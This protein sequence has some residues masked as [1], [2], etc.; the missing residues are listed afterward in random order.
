M[1]ACALRMASYSLLAIAA[2]LL[3][4]GLIYRLLWH[5]PTVYRYSLAHYVAARVRRFS[6]YPAYL[7]FLLRL[8][9]LGLLVFVVGRPQLP[10]RRT[11][12]NVEG[13]DIIL[14]MDV[15]GSMTCFDDMVDRRSRICVAKQEAI[16]FIEQREH[17]AVGVVV[18][19]NG[20]LSACPLT[21]DKAALREIVQSLDVGT[22]VDERCT[23]LSCG[24]LAALNRLKDTQ[25]TSKIIILLTDGQPSLQDVCVQ[26]PIS[27][28][29]R[30]GVKIYTIGIGN[31]QGGFSDVGGALMRAGVELN[32]PLLK[33]IAQQTGGAYYRAYTAGDVR[34][35]YAL[36]DQLEKRQM[37]INWYARYYDIFEPIIWIVLVTLL[38]E[39]GLATFVW[40][41]L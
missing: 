16:R 19:G 38:L 41:G 28:A 34:C 27:I 39:Y 29:Q 37:P 31:Q 9:G 33:L 4:L 6:A 32:E 7:F 17:D 25:S 11:H 12:I 23:L 40:R 26:V 2:G 15:S 14:V 13:I 18:F 1:D 3:L 35:I 30:M 24:M 36:I 10:D 5:R 8:I 21:H 20:A 22:M